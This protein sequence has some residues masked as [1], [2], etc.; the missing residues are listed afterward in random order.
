MT[1]DLPAEALAKAGEEGAYH[2]DTEDT[3]KR[4]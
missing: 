1:A 3:E 2:G 4:G